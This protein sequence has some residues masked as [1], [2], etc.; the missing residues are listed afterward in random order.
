MREAVSHQGE[1]SQA[2]HAALLS[3]FQQMESRL[4]MEVS[5]MRSELKANLGDEAVDLDAKEQKFIDQI[6]TL[7]PQTEAAA[8][9]SPAG[10]ALLHVAF[11]S[12][13]PALLRPMT[14]LKTHCVT[15]GV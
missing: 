8:R 12:R 13:I 9:S 14:R 11:Y 3:L 6:V 7:L 15:S 4:K 1:Q 2:Q 10:E 5:D